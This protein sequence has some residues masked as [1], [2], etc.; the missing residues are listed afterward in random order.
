MGVWGYVGTKFAGFL[1]LRAR[2]NMRKL[3]LILVILLS[4]CAAAGNYSRCG[5]RSGCSEPN[6]LIVDEA[7]HNRPFGP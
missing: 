1:A 5:D 7:L 3:A 6:S 2:C 4:G